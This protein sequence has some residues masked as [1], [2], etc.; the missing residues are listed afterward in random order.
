MNTNQ[1]PGYR[2]L[3]QL[4]K[5]KIDEGQ[6]ELAGEILEG[7]LAMP[8]LNSNEIFIVVPCDHKTSPSVFANRDSANV[9]RKTLEECGRPNCLCVINLTVLEVT[10]W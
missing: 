5:R 9:E 3:L 10:E 7:L 4:C 2:Q 1:N 8:A 6:P